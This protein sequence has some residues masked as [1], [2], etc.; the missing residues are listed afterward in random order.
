MR[1]K[2]RVVIRSYDKG[3]GGSTFC[4]L[5]GK[6]MDWPVY[7]WVT[8]ENGANELIDKMKLTRD[9]GVKEHLVE[10]YLDWE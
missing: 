2:T 10:M 3:I 1:A 5:Q 8:D 9:G 7:L 6:N 4:L